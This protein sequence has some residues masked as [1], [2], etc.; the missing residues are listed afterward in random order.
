LFLRL[1]WEV[2]PFRRSQYSILAVEKN[3]FF[4][5]VTFAWNDGA[6]QLYGQSK[7]NGESMTL[8]S[9]RCL[10][11]ACGNSLRGDDG[12]GPWLAEWAEDR[13]RSEPGLR[14]VACQQWTPE[15]AEEVASAESVLFIDC[16]VDSAPGVLWLA[17]VVSVNA[18][19]GLATHRLG[20]AELFALGR[21]L[22]DSAPRNALLMTIGAGSTE[23]G[24]EFSEAVKASL[25]K[26]CRLLEETVLRLLCK[27][28]D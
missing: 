23:I 4:D 24:E 10:I 13:F 3:R 19:S 22:Y 26:A 27:T 28:A 6:R 7:T 20:A 12:V 18:A 1:G 21:E 15:L 25:P 8:T 9:A 11:L 2:F 5:F 17:P 16:A 14:V